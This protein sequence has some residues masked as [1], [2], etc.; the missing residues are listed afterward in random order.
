MNTMNNVS[1]ILSRIRNLD[2]YRGTIAQE[3]LDLINRDRTNLFPWRGQFSPQLIE[4]LLKTYATRH[5]VVLD[6]FAGSGT[7]LFEASRIPLNCFATE[8]NPAAVEM[9]RTADFINVKNIKRE[10]YIREAKTVIQ[11]HFPSIDERKFFTLPNKKGKLPIEKVFLKML[12]DGSCEPL[13]HNI[14]IN[15]LI[16]YFASN[17]K[18]KRDPLTALLAAF[19]KHSH[20]IRALPYNNKSCKVY[21]CDARN[22]PFEDKSIHLI[23]TS[24]PYIN[25]FNYHQNS[26]KAMEIEGWDLLKI[27]KSEIGSN[28]KNRGNRFLTIVQ[29]A[30]DML[31][32]FFEMRRVVKPNGRIIVIIGRESRVRRVSFENYKILLAIALGG[33][34]LKLICKQERKFIN[35]FGGTIYEDILH[36]MPEREPI[37]SPDDLARSVG[38]YF[39]KEA[40]D[41]AAGEVKEDIE[42]AIENT[43]KVTPSPL[44]EYKPTKGTSL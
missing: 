38:I 23:V 35:R 16:R 36:F 34:G 28:R 29:Y 40:L 26:R 43:G 19:K 18:N 5:T 14:V 17:G 2:A 37:G 21:Q 4:L 15:T 33:A 20:I 12:H 9:A 44:F 27:A 13:V 41:K 32:A 11:R 7:T 22:L 3:D 6:P 39:L 8:I 10:K 1:S 31:Q 24:P 42:L 30:I 25:V